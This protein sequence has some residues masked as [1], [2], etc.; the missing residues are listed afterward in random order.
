[1]LEKF[2]QFERY[3]D[4]LPRIFGVTVCVRHPDRDHP[5]PRHRQ[6]SVELDSMPSRAALR[7]HVPE[8]HAS[9]IG[10]P[11]TSRAIIRS[12]IP[13]ADGAG[14]LYG[15]REYPEEDLAQIVLTLLALNQRRRYRRNNTGLPAA[16]GL[17][18][19]GH[20]ARTA[21]LTRHP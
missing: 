18:C 12:D 11:R 5:Q 14:V 10:T 9:S 20:D 17:D 3:R 21:A 1:M 13:P 2:A 16:Q 7:R 6:H 19:C 4:D 8:A 15:V